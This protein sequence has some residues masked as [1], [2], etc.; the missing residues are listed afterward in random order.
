MF[1]SSKFFDYL[2]NLYNI[3]QMKL[4]KK[5]FILY[6]CT[7][8]ECMADLKSAATPFSSK[9]LTEPY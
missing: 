5:L 7:F 4:K 3:F 2:T 9:A 6:N 8:Q 1:T